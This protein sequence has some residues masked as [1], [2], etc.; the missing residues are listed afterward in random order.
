MR[1]YSF[2][3][4]KS[5]IWG[6]SYK[7]YYDGVIDYIHQDTNIVESSFT[8]DFWC[9]NIKETGIQIDYVLADPDYMKKENDR[10]HNSNTPHSFNL[11]GM[12]E[13]SFIS[14]QDMHSKLPISDSESNRYNHIAITF[15]NKT[16]KISFFFNG[17]LFIGNTYSDLTEKIQDFISTNKYYTEYYFKFDIYADLYHDSRTYATSYI[18]NRRLSNKVLWD[19]DFDPP[20]IDSKQLFYNNGNAYGVI[21]GASQLL[22]SNWDLLAEDQ[23]ISI[24]NSLDYDILPSPE[25]MTKFIDG[26]S[27]PDI[28]SKVYS[29]Q[30][31]IF[32]RLSINNL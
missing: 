9:S 7:V 14:I 8:L 25:E 13:E 29:F 20:G 26:D 1:L 23:K 31:E 5:N 4:S 6:D 32:I 17:K 2:Q 22:S 15:D 21:D 30:K 27:F 24:I 11:F 16:K 12:T 19:K 3:D 28:D 10:D 18:D